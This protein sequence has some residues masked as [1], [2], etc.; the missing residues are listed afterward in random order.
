MPINRYYPRIERVILTA[1]WHACEWSSG[2][3]TAYDL[4]TMQVYPQ[5]PLDNKYNTDDDASF[6]LT[7]YDPDGKVNWEL[8]AQADDIGDLYLPK[9]TTCTVWQPEDSP[10]GHWELL[11]AGETCPTTSGS[12]GSEGGSEE[13]S[14]GSAGG[15]YPCIKAA[16]LGLDNV[17][18]YSEGSV[19][20]LTHDAHGCLA[21][22]DAKP[23][24]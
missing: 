8:A 12:A 16:H 13:G 7:L 21:W 1:D 4:E 6:S 15:A 18:G 10:D 23:C 9:G 20:V 17:A 3:R 24:P 11:H 14:A 19:Q 22:I 5:G 2:T